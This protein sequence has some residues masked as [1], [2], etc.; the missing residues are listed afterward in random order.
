[1]AVWISAF[2]TDT[3]AGLPANLIALAPPSTKFERPPAVLIPIGTPGVDHAG[4]VF[5]MDNLV[6]L[7]LQALL[8][9]GLPSAAD[10]LN[11]IA[12]AMAKERSA[13]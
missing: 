9:R 10:V 7:P 12:Q 5:R 8:Q 2:R 13:A 4:Q 1:L 3:P 6:A 11:R